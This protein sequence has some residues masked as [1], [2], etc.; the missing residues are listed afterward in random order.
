MEYLQA[1]LNPQWQTLALDTRL[2]FQAIGGRHPRT[3]NLSRKFPGPDSLSWLPLW[4]IGYTGPREAHGF[5]SGVVR[6]LLT[7]WRA[8]RAEIAHD[9]VGEPLSAR[10]EF[11]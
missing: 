3:D 11:V 10:H 9:R 6:F 2:A 5:P 1:L 8:T 7:A 4:N